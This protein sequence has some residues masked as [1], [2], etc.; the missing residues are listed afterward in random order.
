[1]RR[2]W[3]GLSSRIFS[4]AWIT[5]GRPWP[6]VTDGFQIERLAARGFCLVVGL[7]LLLGDGGFTPKPPRVFGKRASHAVLFDNLIKFL[8]RRR[9]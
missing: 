8:E 7:R 1:M 9:V 4:R 5:S 2:A 6:R 3:R